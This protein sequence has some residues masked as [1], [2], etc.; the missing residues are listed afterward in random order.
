M[1]IDSKMPPTTKKPSF[2]LLLKQHHF[3]SLIQAIFIELSCLFNNFPSYIL[4]DEHLKIK[5]KAS[6]M[7]GLPAPDCSSWLPPSE[8]AEQFLQK[9][10]AI[11]PPPRTA[12]AFSA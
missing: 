9:W 11:S 1:G 8:A 7:P 12:A 5:R 6:A 4:Q 10:C 2:S 3:S